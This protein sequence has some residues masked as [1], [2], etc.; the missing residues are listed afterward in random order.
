MPN[1][2]QDSSFDH[3][4]LGASLYCLG[5]RIHTHRFGPGEHDCHIN[6]SVCISTSS[7]LTCIGHWGN[8]FPTDFLGA[9][10]R[11]APP[12][13]D[14][15]GTRFSSLKDCSDR[16]FKSQVLGLKKR[17]LETRMKVGA[18]WW[19]ATARSCVNACY[20]VQV[21]H[22]LRTWVVTIL[23]RFSW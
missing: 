3:E 21:L 14:P 15:F 11:A 23:A 9:I 2:L 12:D 10:Q 6:Q 4:L 13:Y 5:G 22:W 16:V 20:P 8:A 17:L 1:Y 19:N 7:T 18:I